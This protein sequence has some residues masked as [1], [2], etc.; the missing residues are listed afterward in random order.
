ML[1]NWQ[2]QDLC[3]VFEWWHIHSVTGLLFSCLAVFGIA[4]GYEY[5]RAQTATLDQ[6]WYEANSKKAADEQY[7]T[8][9]GEQETLLHRATG[10]GVAR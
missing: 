6:M 5:L 2:V 1:F 8:I 10:P 7:E 3:V 9:A 4:A